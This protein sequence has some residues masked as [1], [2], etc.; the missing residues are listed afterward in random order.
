MP[1]SGIPLRSSTAGFDKLED[2]ETGKP[3]GWR[4]KHQGQEFLQGPPSGPVG[5]IPRVRD[6]SFSLLTINSDGQPVMGKFHASGD[7]RRSLVVIPSERREDS[8][9]G[10]PGQAGFS[11]NRYRQESSRPA[12]IRC[13]MPSA[14]KVQRLTASFGH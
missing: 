10:K 2:Y 14:K 4:T 12:L 7:E 6:C 5:E 11:S 3:I 9:H 1:E 8:Q 13:L